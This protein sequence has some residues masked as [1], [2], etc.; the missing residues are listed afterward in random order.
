[1]KYINKVVGIAFLFLS[2][3]VQG[4]ELTLKVYGVCGMCQ[5]RIESNAKQVIGV[6]TASWE[7][8]TMMLTITYSEGLFVEK[9]LH[10]KM[11]SLGHDTDKMKSPD[12]IYA[13][14]HGCCKYRTDENSEEENKV[15][16]QFQIDFKNKVGEI[17]ETG[18]TLS[19]MIY[20]QESSGDLVPLVGANVYLAETM[21]GTSTD[22]DGYFLFHKPKDLSSELIVISYTGYA[23]DTILGDL[24]G[25]DQ[26]G[27]N[28]LTPGETFYQGGDSG[29]P[30][31]ILGEGQLVLFGIHSFKAEVSLAP[32]HTT[33][34]RQASGDVYLPFYRQLILA[35]GP[36]SELAAIPEPSPFYLLTLCFALSF[37][38]FR[39]RQ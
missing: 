20:E 4:Q 25:N 19:G 27:P 33:F 17:D 29:A 21:E 12:E 13:N 38:K 14:L 23:N 9:E 2:V 6:N 3:A 5:E 35:S 36:G 26:P 16:E 8:E 34:E 39:A 15:V 28:L 10:E 1:M 22:A 30:T 7:S 18:A 31:F 32:P 37:V 24:T 11:I